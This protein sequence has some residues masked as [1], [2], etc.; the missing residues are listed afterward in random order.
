MQ[1]TKKYMLFTHL[2]CLSV[3]IYAMIEMHIQQNLEAL[4]ALIGACVADVLAN[5]FYMIKAY[6]ETNSEAK[7]NIERDRMNMSISESYEDIE[8]ENDETN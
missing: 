1:T 7:I 5:G 6:M 2:L 3:I 8:Y 4:T